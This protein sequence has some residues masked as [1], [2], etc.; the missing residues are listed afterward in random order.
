M[1]NSQQWKLSHDIH[2]ALKNNGI[3]VKTS[4]IKHGTGAVLKNISR[5]TTIVGGSLVVVSILNDKEV[6]AS[7][8]LNGA[9]VGITMIPTIGWI[10]G[11]TFFLADM[12]TLGIS[13]QTIGSH[14][15]NA[16]GTPLIE[17]I[18]F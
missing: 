11:G 13:G 3:N 2:K 10:A 16:F 8:I 5:G 14:L 6:R 15:D 12:I 18:R 9:M 17:N 7:H 1:N 4:A